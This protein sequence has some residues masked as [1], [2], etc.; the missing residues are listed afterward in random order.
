MYDE[1]LYI[2]YDG[3]LGVCIEDAIDDMLLIIA[4]LW[5]FVAIGYGIIKNNKKNAISPFVIIGLL[6]GQSAFAAFIDPAKLGFVIALSLSATLFTICAF[7]DSK[8]KAIKP[9]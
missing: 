4:I 9:N 1:C 5:F 3:K 6:I 2:L 8:N 7:I